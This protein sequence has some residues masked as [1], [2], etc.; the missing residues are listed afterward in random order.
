MTNLYNFRNLELDPALARQ[1]APFVNA[2]RPHDKPETSWEIRERLGID[3][4][5]IKVSHCNL[6][7]LVEQAEMMEED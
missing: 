7:G 2:H 3:K 4:A 5:I 6:A 1:L